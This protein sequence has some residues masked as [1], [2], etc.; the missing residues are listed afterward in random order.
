LRHA[1]V[2]ISAGATAKLF[3]DSFVRWRCCKTFSVLLK[4]MFTD[5]TLRD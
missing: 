2:R 5:H 4:E 1:G 3:I